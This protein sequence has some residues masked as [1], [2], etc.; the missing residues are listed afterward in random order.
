MTS[1]PA[2]HRRPA[3]PLALSGPVTM[4]APSR[5]RGQT[6]PS[7]PAARPSS[8]ATSA[9]TAIEEIETSNCPLAAATTRA[10]AS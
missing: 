7:P 6:V 8:P 2:R 3:R 5:P 9:S 10:S 1:Q 4:P